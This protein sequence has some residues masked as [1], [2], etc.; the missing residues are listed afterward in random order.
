MEKTAEGHMLF[1]GEIWICSDQKYGPPWFC[2]PPWQVPWSPAFLLPTAASGCSDL[3][4]SPS[5][6]YGEFG[7][8]DTNLRS[9]GTPLCAP[10]ERSDL[11][12]T[13]GGEREV[14]HL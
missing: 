12:E 3:F 5:L 9:V 8:G 4:R 6:D 7:V 2:S 1:S 11:L 10:A 13:D 14:S